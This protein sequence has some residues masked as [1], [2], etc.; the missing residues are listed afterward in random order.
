MQ[1]EPSGSFFGAR[2]KKSD[3]ERGRGKTFPDID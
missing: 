3:L 1:K 2:T